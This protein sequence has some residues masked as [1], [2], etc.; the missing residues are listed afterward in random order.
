[1]PRPGLSMSAL[2]LLPS[3]KKPGNSNYT[4]EGSGAVP[5]SSYER[6]RR[7]RLA[8]F[9]GICAGNGKPS[10]T[11]DTWLKTHKNT[12]VFLW[13]CGCVFVSE[14][15]QFPAQAAEDAF[16]QPGDIG[17]GNADG[18]CHLLLGVFGAAP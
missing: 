8:P 7:R 1:M 11:P 15:M 16:F 10:D 18:I 14:V 4:P 3:E 9:L 12:P 2:P 17:L 6:V 5:V 13:E